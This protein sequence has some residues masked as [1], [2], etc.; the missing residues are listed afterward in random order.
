MKNFS[1]TEKK[2]RSIYHKQ[3]QAYLQ[4]RSIFNRFYRS[5]VDPSCYGVDEAFFKSITVLDAGCGNT[6]YFQKALQK[7]CQI[8]SQCRMHPE[9]RKNTSLNPILNCRYWR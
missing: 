6:G 3:H 4:D 8:S 2:T 7:H 9:Y 1:S 5:A